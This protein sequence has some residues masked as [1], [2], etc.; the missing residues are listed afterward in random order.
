MKYIHHNVSNES[1]LYE[2]YVQLHNDCM[3]KKIFA[4][5]YDD[6]LIEMY[7]DSRNKGAV[8]FQ[9]WEDYEE[10]QIIVDVTD[11]EWLNA[12]DEY[13]QQGRYVITSKI[14]KKEVEARKN[15]AVNSV[16]MGPA[17]KFAVR[18]YE[19]VKFICKDKRLKSL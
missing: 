10:P 11:E 13:V 6:Y 2:L 16:E 1:K 12:W 3:L 8:A 4:V 5:P 19:T 15:R 9:Y 7:I 17:E 18:L 14:Y